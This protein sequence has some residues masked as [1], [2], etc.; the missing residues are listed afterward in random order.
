VWTSFEEFRNLKAIE[1]AES[2]QWLLASETR[3]WLFDAKMEKA[4]EVTLIDRLAEVRRGLPRAPEQF[5]QIE[6]LTYDSKPNASWI[7]TMSDGVFLISH[8]SG[9][10]THPPFNSTLVQHCSAPHVYWTPPKIYIWNDRRYLTRYACFGEIK[11]D[12]FVRSPA[13]PPQGRSFSDLLPTGD[14]DVEFWLATTEGLA[15]YDANRDDLTDNRPS[16]SEPD[17]NA[18]S[19]MSVARGKVWVTY[20]N[21][22]R[23]S[24]LDTETGLWHTLGAFATAPQLLNASQ[25]IPKDGCL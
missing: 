3:V 4:K 19:S 1:P 12:T 18:V 16:F 8:Q 24:V 13:N 20:Y 2:G 17:G 7:G 5:M 15:R 21:Y 25:P 6:T 14:S 11:D 9:V 23:P 10:V 22:E